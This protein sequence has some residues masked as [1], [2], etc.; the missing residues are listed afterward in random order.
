MPGC[1]IHCPWQSI[2]IGICEKTADAAPELQH[3]YDGPC[4]QP[5]PSAEMPTVG[6]VGSWMPETNH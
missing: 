3:W 4:H 1:A 2:F 5:V 6:L